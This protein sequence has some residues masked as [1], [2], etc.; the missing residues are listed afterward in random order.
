MTDRDIQPVDLAEI[1]HSA[2]VE[3]A[4]LFENVGLSYASGPHG[5]SNWYLH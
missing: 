1:T 5:P 2:F 4:I 3:F